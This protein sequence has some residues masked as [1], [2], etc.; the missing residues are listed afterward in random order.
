MK[1]WSD[2]Y[3]AAFAAFLMWSSVYASAEGL[4]DLLG[5]QLGKPG[6]EAE[7]KLQAALPK[8]KLQRML[9]NMPTIDK[10]VI[11]S[12]SSAPAGQIMM[13]QEGDQVRVDVTL[14]PNKQTV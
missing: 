9:E 5:V 6:R 13:G 12:F 11:K 10:P 14:P 1:F 3:R 8:N 2:R 4:P 7:A